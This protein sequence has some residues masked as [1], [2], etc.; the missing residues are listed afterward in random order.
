[1]ATEINRWRLPWMPLEISE[2]SVLAGGQVYSQGQWQPREAC[3]HLQGP[4][5]SPKESHR[6]RYH[7]SQPQGDFLGYNQC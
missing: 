2:Q 5:Q 6:P 3:L 7:T 4:H 1:M